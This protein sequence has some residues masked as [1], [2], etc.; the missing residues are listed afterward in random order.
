MSSLHCLLPEIVY[1]IGHIEQEKRK[2]ESAENK[3]DL[4]QGE[5]IKATKGG[6]IPPIIVQ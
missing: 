4:G 1:R 5:S 2:Q 3:V 6:S